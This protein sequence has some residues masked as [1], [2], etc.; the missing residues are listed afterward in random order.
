MTKKLKFIKF[1]YLFGAF[2]DLYFAIALLFPPVWAA[3]FQIQNFQ[4]DL[5]ERLAIMTGG[6]LMSG[7]TCLLIWAQ[8]EPVQRR[9]ILI[10]TFCPVVT[11]FICLVSY[12]LFFGTPEIW[13][14][15]FIL[16]KLLILSFLLIT[17][18]F[19]ATQIEKENQ[20]ANPNNN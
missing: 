2:I 5:S 15:S 4:P 13:N 7:W 14:L 1:V 10:L 17:G 11:G 19:T 8:K 20:N 3:T 16:V 18:F 9:F 12:D 6:C